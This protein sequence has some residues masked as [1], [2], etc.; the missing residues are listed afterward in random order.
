ME[1]NFPQVKPKAKSK[2]IRKIIESILYF[3]EKKGFLQDLSFSPM[4]VFE[5]TQFEYAYDYPQESLRSI[6][7]YIEKSNC[8]HNFNT[9]YYP[10]NAL[11]LANEIDLVTLKKVNYDLLRDLTIYLKLEDDKTGLSLDIGDYEHLGLHFNEGPYNLKNLI[12]RTKDEFDENFGEEIFLNSKTFLLKVNENVYDEKDSSTLNARI[13]LSLIIQRK[14]LKVGNR[15]DFAKKLSKM[16]NDN[17]LLKKTKRNVGEPFS[18]LKNAITQA[19]QILEESG[20]KYI[21]RRCK[22]FPRN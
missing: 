15:D 6:G 14:N 7:E 16:I 21:I 8:I 3:G 19:N 2:I 4:E 11:F 9:T 17:R 20:S 10:S 1:F 13:L 5:N 12:N 22:F 18:T